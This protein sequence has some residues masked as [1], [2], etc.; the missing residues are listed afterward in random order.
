MS[1]RLFTAIIYIPIR[2][3][4]SQFLKYRNI[5][6]VDE[7]KFVTFVRDNMPGADHINFYEKTSKKF[8][9]QVIV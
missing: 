9:K 2:P 3:L 5:K 6:V 8:V 7:N 4:G 1:V